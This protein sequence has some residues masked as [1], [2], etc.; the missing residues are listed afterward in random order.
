MTHKKSSGK[1]FEAREM[2]KIESSSKDSTTNKVYMS[3][4]GFPMYNMTS[5]MTSSATPYM[6]REYARM[7]G[8]RE[9]KN[10]KSNNDLK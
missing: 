3:V 4:T 9:I 10:E 7:Q 2:E 5:L 6:G 8:R 1:E